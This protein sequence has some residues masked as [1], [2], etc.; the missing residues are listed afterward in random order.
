MQLLWMP[1]GELSRAGRV[2]VVS[3]PVTFIKECS[4]IG[5]IKVFTDENF[6]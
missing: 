5:Y 2:T 1:A 3:V 6:I 4:G